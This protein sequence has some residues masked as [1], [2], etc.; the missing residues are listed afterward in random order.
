MTTRATQ[1]SEKNLAAMVWAAFL[2]AFILKLKYM[3]T[4]SLDYAMYH[5][6]YQIIQCHGIVLHKK[7]DLQ[8][9]R[10]QFTTTANLQKWI[11]MND[12]KK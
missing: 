3:D 6:I 4:S 12:G 1:K 7:K 9:N 8:E 11:K 5:S 2:Y 10:R